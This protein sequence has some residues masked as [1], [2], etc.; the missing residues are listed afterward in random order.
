[1]KSYTNFTPKSPKGAKKGLRITCSTYRMA[2]KSLILSSLILAGI[3]SPL[4]AQ[5]DQYSI[6]SWWFGAAAGANFNFYQGTTQ[7]LNSDL[8]VPAAFHHGNGEGLYV[9]PLV[10]YYR[11]HTRLGAML[12]IGYDNRQGTFNQVIS[13]CNCPADLSANISYLTVEPSLRFAPFKSNFYLYAGPRI[14]F[15]LDKSFSYQLK[16]SSSVPGQA[17]GPVEKGD[18]SY[19]NKTLI[20]M[21]IGAG[22]DIP[23]SSQH[24]RTQF[25][26]SPFVSY[27]PYFG[28]DPR[29]IESLTVTT[30]RVGA[31]IKFGRG[32]KIIAPAEI[33]APVVK[34]AVVIDPEVQFTVNA[35]ANIP[36]ERRVKEIFPLRN[37]V[38][39]N[40]GS[41]EIPDRYLL[42]KKDQVKDFKESQVDLFIPIRL[43]GRANRQMTVYYNVINILGD[44]MV[45]YPA[46]T[47]T[48]VGSSEK[49]PKDARK[50]AGS[51]KLYL[52]D[53]FGIDP[54]RISVEGLTKPKIS[55]I[56]RGET[57]E[58][59]LRHEGDRRVS[60][61]SN[62]PVLLMEFQHGPDAPLYPVEI[63]AVK[64][65]PLDSYITFNVEGG[66]NAF[67]S[68][69]LEITDDKGNVQSFGPYSQEQVGIPGKSI[70]GSRPEGQY[71]VT[72]IGHTKSGKT[73]TKDTSVHMVLWTP[74][75]SEEVLQFSILFEY[76]DSKAITI[77][78]KYLTDIV[79]PKIPQ[80]GTV[81]IHGYTDIIG[82]A[83]YNQILSLR[84]ANDVRK[85][86]EKSLATAGRS[87]V[88]F[89]LYGFGA[90][91]NVSPFDNNNPE[92]RFYNRTVIIDLVPHM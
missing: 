36:V 34:E 3:Q 44:R 43:T 23:L 9:A 13:P 29:S 47:I 91:P 53:V 82:N 19:M 27:Q 40:L 71:K 41:D 7:Q 15:N 83:A 1:M 49:G 33:V 51:I 84:R 14:A 56:V 39:F 26:L 75:T 68:W 80:G 57:D 35:P 52:T 55:S 6:P 63:I 61:E 78:E 31:S 12:Q 64:D 67:T 10:E 62:S 28:Q 72:M 4:K 77:Y 8:T 16:A 24:H 81:V 37:Y 50:M 88:K 89:E 90:D 45:R 58:L 74:A 22:Y 76:D 87:D 30:L 70:L 42:L 18:L 20:S 11:E 17:A 32:R 86:I 21:Q 60:I 66:N 25:V 46:T 65:A 38:F 59:V 79:T 48:L 54:S 92:G 2:I 73:V 69:S 85:I 5:M